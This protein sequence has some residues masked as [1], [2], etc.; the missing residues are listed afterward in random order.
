MKSRSLVLPLVT[1]AFAGLNLQ[2]AEPPGRVEALRG[3][4]TFVR[5]G[6]VQRMAV[7]SQ[8][9]PGDAMTT[10]ST[11]QAQLDAGS[12]TVRA[13]STTDLH[14]KENGKGLT[15]KSGIV[16]V[17]NKSKNQGYELETDRH[18]ATSYG[19]M[20]VSYLKDK[21]L[22][23]LCVEGKVK[24]GLKAFMGDSVTLQEGQMVTITPTEDR[25]PEPMN[26][27]LNRV[28]T[29]SA[30]LGPSFVKPGM[31]FPGG[32]RVTAA[33]AGQEKAMAQ[34]SAGVGKG[35]RDETLS[36]SQPT[37]NQL[38]NSSHPLYNE[39]VSGEFFARLNG[40]PINV[41]TM[42]QILDEARSGVPIPNS[43]LTLL[44]RGARR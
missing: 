35:S 17:S 33:I 9:M 10:G 29:T 31:T 2:A 16:L 22:K 7:A 28:A 36:Q 18:R 26:V 32:P 39:S 3:K 6:M 23:V 12:A 27:N 14:L 30:L 19:T 15:L 8:V 40:R 38:T 5:H 42:Y 37:L 11:G 13:G 41:D 24:V 1:I 20:Q 44:R 21:Y 43:K 34:A 25:I 4:T